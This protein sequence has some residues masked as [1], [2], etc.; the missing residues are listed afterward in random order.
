MSVT[1]ASNAPPYKNCGEER[2]VTTLITA[3]KRT[4]I[5]VES[6]RW[7]F[8]M[9]AWPCLGAFAAFPKQNDRV[10]VSVTQASNAPPYK[11]CGEERCVTTLITAAKRTKINVESQR[12]GFCMTAWPCLGAFAAFPK[13]ND[14]CPTKNR[15]GAGCAHLE[16][17]EA[18]VSRTAIGLPGL[19]RLSQLPSTRDK[20]EA[21]ERDDGIESRGRPL[22]SSPLSLIIN[23]NIPQ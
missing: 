3:A 7:G 17:T 19:H 9:T 13:Q 23:S 20:R 14:K 11:N 8:C 1:Q 15:G 21:R 2:C 6:Q 12:W 5:N 16:L 10:R 18:L 4:K 22:P